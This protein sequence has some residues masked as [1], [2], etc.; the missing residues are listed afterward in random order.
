MSEAS[1]S[2]ASWAELKSLFG[3]QP[4]TRRFREFW[5]RADKRERSNLLRNHRVEGQS[6]RDLVEVDLR[7]GADYLLGYYS[8]LEIASLIR[9]VEGTPPDGRDI[10]PILRD[11]AMVRYY[12]EYY[13]VLLPKLFRERLSGSWSRQFDPSAE[14]S[15]AFW[16]FQGFV[17]RNRTNDDLNLLFSF[18][19]GFAVK[20]PDGSPLSLESV[21]EEF[22]RPEQLL[23]TLLREPA[24]QSTSDRVINGL[25][26]FFEFAKEF[27]SLLATVENEW[28]RSEMWLFYDYYFRSLRTQLGRQLD[29]VATKIRAVNERA[30]D[31]ESLSSRVNFERYWSAIQRMMSDECGQPILDYFEGPTTLRS[32]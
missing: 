26:E 16:R 24:H 10:L 4:E 9:Y 5:Y 27:D 18:L 25:R 31:P 20:G 14:N 22:G 7:G 29:A 2:Q 11:E 19:D 21:A 8:I 12:D 17:A 32:A 13:P 3:E 6:V 1:A 23:A 30:D 28:L 15:L